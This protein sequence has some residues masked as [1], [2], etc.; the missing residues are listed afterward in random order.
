MELVE[1]VGKIYE[2]RRDASLQAYAARQKTAAQ[3]LSG[4]EQKPVSATYS[5]THLSIKEYRLD[6]VFSHLIQ[7]KPSVS[8]RV[9]TKFIATK[10]C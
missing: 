6:M 3:V 7:L 8:N 5:F 2:Q 4:Q 1:T 9:R 10:I